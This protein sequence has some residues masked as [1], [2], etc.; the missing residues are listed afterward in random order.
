MILTRNVQY[1]VSWL[2]DEQ[3]NKLWTNAS[4][5]FKLMRVTERDHGDRFGCMA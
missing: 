4:H 5:P 2:N 1:Q 3:V